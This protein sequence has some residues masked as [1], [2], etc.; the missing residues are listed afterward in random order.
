MVTVAAMLALAGCSSSERVLSSL[1]LPGSS[2]EQPSNLVGTPRAQAGA[3]PASNIDP[4]SNCP[5]TDI[6]QGSSTYT[7]SAPGTERTALA[8][9]YQATIARLAR[10][11]AVRGA[12]MTIKVGVQG[13]VILGPAGGPGEIVVPL[14][15]A[16][17]QEGIQPKTIVTKFYRVPVTIPPGQGNVPFTHV[18]EN[19]TFPTPSIAELEKYVIYVGFD[20]QMMEQ[21]PK[22]TERRRRR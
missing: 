15:Y 9:R 17:V 19:L 7:L 20:P 14:R 18:E 8:L 6:R 13:R 22:K 16:L 21:K 4:S 11:C 2:S 5:V 12:T 1:G 3:S 10:E